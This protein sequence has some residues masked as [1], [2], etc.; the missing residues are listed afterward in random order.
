MQAEA[1]VAP[2]PEMQRTILSAPPFGCAE[3]IDWKLRS[4]WR[5]E[6]ELFNADPER[7]FNY[8]KTFGE[9][10]CEAPPELLAWLVRQSKRA[11]GLEIVRLCGDYVAKRAV[12]E[13]R[14]LPDSLCC[15]A[16][17]AARSAF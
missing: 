12:H 9:I 15:V 1:G 7:V 11:T 17:E 13:G 2:G 4:G 5:L 14:A 10:Y 16:G 8:R 6:C 3:S